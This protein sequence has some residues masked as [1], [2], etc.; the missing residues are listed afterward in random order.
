MEELRRGAEQYGIALTGEMLGQFERYREMLLEWNTKMNLTAI[1]DRRE[2]EIKHFL[3]SLLLLRT[4][5]V[6]QGAR[7]IDVGT[8]AGFPG[9]AL[10]IARPDLRLTLLDSLQKRVGFLREVS[11]AL[12]QENLCVHGR[13][14]ELG[15][16]VDFREQYDLATARAVAALPALCEYCL[17]FVRVG[18]FFVALKGPEV[19][20]EV[21]L[22]Q[23]AIGLLGGRVEAVEQFELPMEKRVF[24]KENSFAGRK[25]NGSQKTASALVSSFKLVVNRR[26]LVVIQKI[27]Q[28]PTKYP[29]AAVRITK[30]PL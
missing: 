12:G 9:V 7:L 5:E 17:P 30:S 3:D 6:P 11:G 13:A 23:R 24:P 16:K 22:A 10:K 19:E 26:A 15:R 29:R 25:E 18:G 4:V 28:T 27:S 1:T 21:A 20:G 8:G 2:I 14:E